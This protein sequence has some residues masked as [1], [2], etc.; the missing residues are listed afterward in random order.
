VLRAPVGGGFDAVQG[1]FQTDARAAVSA[2]LGQSADDE[3]L[4]DAR[5]FHAMR[6]VSGIT[7]RWVT[8]GAGWFALGPGRSEL[9]EYT[10]AVRATVPGRFSLPPT[11]LQAVYQPQY[12][13]RST[14]TSLVVEP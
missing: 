5:I 9:Q 12:L 10:F 2:L 13:A 1:T 8:G 11:Q 4:V 6:S 7:R 3:E 14:A